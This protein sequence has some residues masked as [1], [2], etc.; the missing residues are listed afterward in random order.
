MILSSLERLEYRGYDSVGIA[1]ANENEIKVIKMKG[2]VKDFAI[3]VKP[4]KLKGFIALGHTRWATHGAPSDIN[5]HPHSDCSGNITVVHN[6]TITNF[7]ELREELEALGHVFKSET[8]T[9]VIPHLIE[10][11]IKRGKDPFEAFKLA[12]KSI[13]GSYAVVAYVK[14]E[15]RIFFSKRDNPLVVGI[16]E[17]EN[18]VASDIPA[19]LPYTRKVVVIMD[20][21]VGYITPTSVYIEDSYG[22]AVS[23]SFR[24]VDWDVKTAQKGGYPHFMLKE[25]HESPI[26]VRDSI[27]SLRNE[28]GLISKVLDEIIDSNRIIIV[29]SGTSYYAGLYF[30]LLLSSEGY[31]SIP[32]VASEYFTIRARKGDVVFAISQSGETMDVLMAIRK[33][34]NEGA[35]VISLVNVIDSSIARESDYKI[36]M[37]AGP[38]IAVA[39]TKTFTTQIAMLLFLY[40]LIRKESVSYLEEAPNIISSSITIVEGNSKSLGKELSSKQSIYYLG[41]GFGYPFALEGALKIK[42]VAYIH[43]EAY[44]AGESKHGPIALIEDGFP[45]IFINLGTERELLQNN[46]YEMKARGAR[47]F[48]ISVNERLGADEEVLLS[49]KDPRLAPF[50]VIPFIQLLAYYASVAKG[51]D[52]D[53]PRNLAKTVTVE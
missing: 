43:A 3:R 11:F 15:N 40:S 14:G 27:N 53:R 5:A 7:K 30:S 19:F 47:T 50:A 13:R 17:D 25:I 33:F 6:G 46:L 45:V 39:A 10:E 8:D 20:N 28:E 32:L 37:R 49:V 18:Y 42:E 34:K 23:R 21:E 9:E 29:G 41:R 22:R 38:E 26:A 31:S 4:L 1:V 24:I 35:R 52:P 48:A 51:L 16:G 44:P 2:K 12:V 36:Y